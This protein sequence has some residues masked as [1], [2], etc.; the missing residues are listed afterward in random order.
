MVGEFIPTQMILHQAANT[1]VCLHCAGLPNATKTEHISITTCGDHAKLSRHRH[2][3]IQ[4][5]YS[6][7][8]EVG[9][10]ECAEH[11][12]TTHSPLSTASHSTQGVSGHCALLRYYSAKCGQ[13]K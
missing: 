4:Y 13:Q 3:P 11:D 7:L 8:Q 5:V 6:D 12:D 2:F 1:R 10:R 9:G